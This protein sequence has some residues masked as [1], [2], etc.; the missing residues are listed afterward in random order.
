MLDEIKAI[1]FDM[2]GSLLDSMWMWPEVDRMYMEKYSLSM[3]DDFYQAIQG[4]SYTEMAQYFLDTF[5]SL[6]CTLCDIQ[7]E[8]T[9]MTRELY[10][11]KVPLKP[12]A[13]EFLKRMKNAK[14]LMG[15][16]TSNGRELTDEALK[17][18][19]I[20]RYFASV[21]TACEVPRGKPAPDVYLKVAEDLRVS[22]ENCLVFEDIPNGL[23]AG[24]SAGMK[25]CAVE[26]EFSKPYEREKRKIAD[27]YIHDYRQVWEQTYEKCGE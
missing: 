21:R 2:D 23:L 8:W 13:G 18:L 17:A 12:G 10:R 4:K 1:I 5:P 7:N 20:R 19:H 24:T 6:E 27:Y 22:P 9:D 16:A 15:I 26:D 11:T 25:V 3:P 14:I